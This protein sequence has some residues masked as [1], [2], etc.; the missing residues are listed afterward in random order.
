MTAQEIVLIAS[1]ATHAFVASVWSSERWANLGLK[2][3]FT[4]MAV[5]MCILAARGF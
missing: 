4:C 3:I 1:A 2:F 5:A